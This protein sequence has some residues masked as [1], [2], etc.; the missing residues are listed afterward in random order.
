MKPIHALIT[1]I[2]VCL[3]SVT[4]LSGCS[5]SPLNVHW[6]SAQGDVAPQW[7]YQ[8]PQGHFVSIGSSDSSLS[9]A[10]EQAKVKASITIS[11]RVNFQINHSKTQLKTES[12]HSQVSRLN[13]KSNLNSSPDLL[14]MKSSYQFIE[15]TNNQKT[16]YNCFLLI[17][18]PEHHY[19]KLQR[20][21]NQIETGFANERR[22]LLDQILNTRSHKNFDQWVRSV[23]N[24]MQ[25]SQG[26]KSDSIN[27]Q[28]QVLD[29]AWKPFMQLNSTFSNTH[30]EGVEYH[31][32]WEAQPLT[33]HFT[34]LSF[35]QF[36][37][38]LHAKLRRETIQ[39][40]TRLHISPASSQQIEVVQNYNLQ[41]YLV[42]YPSQ[43][44]TAKWLEKLQIFLAEN[45]T[46]LILTPSELK[47]SVSLKIQA[48]PKW[49]RTRFYQGD[50][51]SQLRF[52]I[53]KLDSLR[54]Y[55]SSRI[56]IFDAW[57]VSKSW[58]GKV[59]RKK[60]KSL[61]PYLSYANES[62]EVSDQFMQDLNRSYQS[63]FNQGDLELAV[64]ITHQSKILALTQ[65]EEVTVKVPFHN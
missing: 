10:L 54:L 39:G 8:P 6:E 35:I 27:F 24:A 1:G 37:A 15:N 5:T 23:S 21:E 30:F 49:G 7:A 53:A 17:S 42:A 18:F 60:V 11:E 16:Q 19:Q 9:H 36:T 32:S 48:T 55:P 65:V 14:I 50:T 59:S 61:S 13:V 28:S 63:V 45:T 40:K 51:L 2:L 33:S 52:Q 26:R 4:G 57:I 62:F 46:K 12:S 31:T 38:P 20:K 3:L 56:E 64:R 22:R 44:E 43:S 47:Q 29:A 25:Y 58:T 41:P 34:D